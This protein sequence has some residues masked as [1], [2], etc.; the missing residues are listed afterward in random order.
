MPN[1]RWK[2]LHESGAEVWNVGVIIAVVV[3]GASAT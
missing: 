1:E 2:V 3:L